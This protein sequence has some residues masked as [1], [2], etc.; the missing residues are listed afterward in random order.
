MLAWNTD[1][2][3]TFWLQ[4]G[5]WLGAGEGTMSADAERDATHVARWLEL[6]LEARGVARAMVDPE[7]KRH[8][9][10]LSESYRVLAKRAELRKQRLAAVAEAKRKPRQH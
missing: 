6:E 8:M 10:F 9:L 1:S 4:A 2:R 5:T 3:E 7:A